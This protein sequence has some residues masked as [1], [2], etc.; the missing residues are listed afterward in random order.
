MSRHSTENTY[1]CLLLDRW[2]CTLG[3]LLSS[4]IC[5]ACKRLYPE[6]IKH[7]FVVCVGGG[8][9]PI[10]QALEF[11][12]LEQKENTNSDSG[13]GKKKKKRREKNKGP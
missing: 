11:E 5:K 13:R 3:V 7:V 4:N 12:N 6:N 10:L 9:D 8:R 2:H 1:L